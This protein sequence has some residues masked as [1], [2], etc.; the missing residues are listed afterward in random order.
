M[1]T[2]ALAVAAAFLFAAALTGCS[3]AQMQK[4]NE[5]L[6]SLVKQLSDK[7]LELEKAMLAKDRFLGGM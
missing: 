3:N 6:K 5:N 4:D 2:P 1:R 7:N